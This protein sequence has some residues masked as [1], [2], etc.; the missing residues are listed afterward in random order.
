M[1]PFYLRILALTLQILTVFW[2]LGSTLL[3]P[4]TT[5]ES[6]EW[7]PLQEPLTSTHMIEPQ[8]MA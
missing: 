2:K 4:S 6:V 8:K 7:V 5:Q 1:R 3:F